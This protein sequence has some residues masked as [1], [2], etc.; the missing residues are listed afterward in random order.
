[1][2]TIFIEDL[3]IDAIVGIYEWER[4]VP[5]TLVLNVTMASDIRTAARTEDIA[6]AINYAEVARCLE[7]LI[8][9]EKYR[10]VE[11]LVEGCADLLLRE[12]G[13]P[14]VK[15]RC[16]KTHVMPQARGVGVEIERGKRPVN[17]V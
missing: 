2:D 14:W 9:A 11:S 4:V 3:H 17:E 7:Q 13:S 5:Q 6:K 12:F 10:L 1:M 8:C 16:R 15:I